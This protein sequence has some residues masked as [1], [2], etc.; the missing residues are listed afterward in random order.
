MNLSAF[1]RGRPWSRATAISLRPGAAAC[2]EEHEVETPRNGVRAANSK[3]LTIKAS[4]GRRNTC[5]S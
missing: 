5:S 1:D 3:R 4:T 2:S